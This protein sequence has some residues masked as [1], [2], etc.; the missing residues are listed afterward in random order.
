MT[1][2]NNRLL[3][4]SAPEIRYYLGA[5]DDALRG[6]SERSSAGKKGAETLVSLDAWYQGLPREQGEQPPVLS[7]K[8]DLVRLMRWKLAREKFRPTLIALIES[9]TE[10][11]VQD[12]LRRA[13]ETL[14]PGAADEDVAN[15]RDAMVSTMKI[16]AELRGVGP[17]TASAITAAW[18]PL[19][20][21]QSDELATLLLP[22]L[23]RTTSPIKYDW[24]YYSAFYPAALETLRGLQLSHS[25]HEWDGR[26][27]ERLAWSVVHSPAP[28]KTDELDG[29]A[30]KE[31]PAATQTP[32]R[33]KRRKASPKPH[34]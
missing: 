30:R 15:S 9:N 20:I 18:H 12:V 26:L 3:G 34:A 21:F 6:K 1:P 17:A 28:D 19:G 33:S 32:H 22:L 5:Y 2:V 23:P 8:P 14:A 7:A 25:D 31:P 13:Y 16:L 29:K 10:T 24:K 4:L 27:L 11:V